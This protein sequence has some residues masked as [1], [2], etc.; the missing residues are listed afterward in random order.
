MIEQAIVICEPA[1]LDGFITIESMSQ[2]GRFYN[3]KCRNLQPNLKL[4][5]I[6]FGGETDITISLVSC[7]FGIGQ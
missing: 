4:E 7:D 6:R 3:K 1:P 5:A 2:V